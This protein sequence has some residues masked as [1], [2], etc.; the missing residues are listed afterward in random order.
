MFNWTEDVTVPKLTDVIET[1]DFPMNILR[2]FTYAWVWFLGGW[3]F[4]AVI[5]V[6]AAALY[7]KYDNAMVSVAFL[8][9]MI[10][11]FGGV[12]SASPIGGYGSAEIFRFIIGVII[13]FVIGIALF[14]T[15][16]NKGE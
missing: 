5:G 10:I 1:S 11:L 16:V 3:F 8:I 7:I 9:T 6:F 2:M 14:M 4:A 15:F 13:A 12:I